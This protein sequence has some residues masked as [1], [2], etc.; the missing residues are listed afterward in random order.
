M[1]KYTA[2]IPVREGSTRLKNKNIAPFAG[3]NLL[4]FKIQQLKQVADIGQIVVSS[5]SDLMLQMAK[6]QGVLTHKR[7]PEYCDEKTKTF[8]EVVRHIA[9]S[10]DS[11]N[12]VW[13]TCTTPL[14][15]PKYY[16][17]AIRVYEQ[18]LKDGYDSLMSVE[19]FK[20]YVWDEKGPLN[21]QLGLA[22]VPSQQL[23][24]LYFVTAGILIGSRKKMIEW[25]YFHG[26]HPLKFPLD[27]RSAVDI[28]DGLDLAVARAWLDMDDS[29]SQIDPYMVV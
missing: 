1:V 13:A 23:K 16:R 27:K 11:E 20:R 12:I 5:D 19:P 29:V 6:S 21:Y 9:E 15:F 4:I 22:H 24:P 2:V 28:D 14:V 17:E 8:G 26:P 18:A 3:V 7:A 10:V 25:N